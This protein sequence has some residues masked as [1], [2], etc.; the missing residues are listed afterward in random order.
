MNGLAHGGEFNARTLL[1]RA[2]V[3]QKGKIFLSPEFGGISH[4]ISE[5]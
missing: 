4:E 1:L 3:S 5:I 2:P